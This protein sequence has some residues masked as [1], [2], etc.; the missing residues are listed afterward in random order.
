MDR[1]EY[2]VLDSGAEE[3]SLLLTTIPGGSQ[4]YS[5][6]ERY[7]AKLDLGRSGNFGLFARVY[8]RLPPEAIADGGGEGDPEDALREI[9]SPTLQ[10]EVL[11]TDDPLLELYAG[12]A[13]QNQLRGPRTT[14]RT[15]SQRDDQHKGE[16]AFDGRVGTQW[17]SA[18]DDPK[19][20]IH[21]ELPRPVRGDLLLLTLASDDPGGIAPKDRTSANSP[22]EIRKV[23]VTINASKVSFE[24]EVDGNP[25]RKVLVPLGRSTKVNAIDLEVLE[26]REGGREDQGVGFAEI[27][28]VT[29]KDR[30]R[31]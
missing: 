9:E 1:V 22:A 27:E 7:A 28:L 6:A 10:I 15:S 18:K 21:I 24:V 25:R 23:R 3:G 19:P 5:P 31:R 2:R 13:R 4:P 29:E 17:I 16:S 12:D 14:A 8:L 30:V 20:S 11:Q 26:V